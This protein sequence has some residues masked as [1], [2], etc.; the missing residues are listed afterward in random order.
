MAVTSTYLKKLLP[1]RKKLRSKESVKKFNENI[2]LH[3]IN[4]VNAWRNV[5]RKS[6]LMAKKHY[7]TNLVSDDHWT[8]KQPKG[9]VHM[10]TKGFLTTHLF[11]C[12]VLYYKWKSLQKDV[13][14]IQLYS[15]YDIFGIIICG[16]LCSTML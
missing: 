15:T 5:K 16:Q 13:S 8:P 7:V 12:H 1:V 3:F 10:V 6:V 4:S 9:H 2:I 11:H 14:A